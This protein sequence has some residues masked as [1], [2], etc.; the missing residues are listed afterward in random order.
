[1]GIFDNIFGHCGGLLD[2]VFAM[3]DW[4][5][6]LN[7]LYWTD[8]IEYL[9]MLNDIKSK[10]YKVLRNSKGKHKIEVRY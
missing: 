6:K 9:R 8:S 4:Q 5:E 2:E 7:K 10:G 3:K 1:M